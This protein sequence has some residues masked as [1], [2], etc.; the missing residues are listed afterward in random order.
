[1]TIG[2]TYDGRIEY[3]PVTNGAGEMSMGHGEQ[4][5]FG[6]PFGAQKERSSQKRQLLTN[7][8]MVI[9]D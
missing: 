3:V 7:D 2:T 9:A 8:N 4:L 6:L 5:I 1:M